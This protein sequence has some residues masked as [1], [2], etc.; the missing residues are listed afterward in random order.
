LLVS[1]VFSVAVSLITVPFILFYMLRD[2]KNFWKFIKYIIPHD[3]RAQIDE[4]LSDIDETIGEYIRGQIT[5]SFLV[6]ICLFIGYSIIGLD[7]AAILAIVA[8]FTNFIPY[9]GPF[10]AVVPALVV[11]ITMS[12]GM[13]LKML[14][15]TV[16][17]QTIEGNLITPNIM[18][19]NLEIHPLTI[20]VIPLFAGSLAGAVGVILAVPVY[21][22]I[23]VIYCHI[24]EY[25]Q[26]K[27]TGDKVSSC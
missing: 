20:I 2:E 4:V 23:K 25:L 22:V 11:A 10:I 27:I 8:M 9:L 24:R 16:V 14:I 18:G 6:G 12:P 5:V 19:R 21:A 7:Y 13:I 1:W 26:P 3:K 15:V 17:V